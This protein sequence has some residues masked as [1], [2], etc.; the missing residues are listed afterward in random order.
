MRT[1][2]IFFNGKPTFQIGTPVQFGIIVLKVENLHLLKDLRL[3]SKNYDTMYT[4]KL[5]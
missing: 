3:I 1:M 5:Q 2:S 4:E